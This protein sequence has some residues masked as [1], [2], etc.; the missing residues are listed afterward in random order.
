VSSLPRSNTRIRAFGGACSKYRI[1][2]KDDA[3][4]VPTMITS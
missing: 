1:K 4:P 3:K 2:K